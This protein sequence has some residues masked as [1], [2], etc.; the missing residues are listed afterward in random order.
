MISNAVTLDVPAAQPVRTPH[1]I[2][3]HQRDNVV[4]VANDGGLPP[5]AVLPSGLVLRDRVPMSVQMQTRGS[6]SS[7]CSMR[8]TSVSCQ[9]PVTLIAAPQPAAG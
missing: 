9:T 7:V 3:M 6:T 1:T 2:R 4:I 8:A 5:G